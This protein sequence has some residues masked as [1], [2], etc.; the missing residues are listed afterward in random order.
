M[1]RRIWIILK[2]EYLSRLK[3]KGFIIGT[4]LGPVLILGMTFLPA[5]LAMMT[6]GDAKTVY[7]YDQTG[8]YGNDLLSTQQEKADLKSLDLRDVKNN[9]MAEQIAQEKTSD[10]LNLKISQGEQTPEQ[11]SA[12]MNDSLA[13][14]SIYGYLLISSDSL[15]KPQLTFYSTSTSDY[16]IL[17]TLERRVNSL[18]RLKN[19]ARL[20]VS[21]ETAK[22]INATVSMKVFKVTESG[23]QEDSGSSLM[24]A[25]GMGFFIYMS[26]F[27]YGSIVM[28][29]AMEEKQSRIV[30]VIISSVR[31][32]D[33]L[34]GKILGIGLL[35]LTQYL[36]WGLTA[37][38]IGL[39]G[40]A[41][42][43]AFAGPGAGIGFSVPLY[44]IVAFIFYFIGGYLIFST[45]Y[46]A[47]GASV[48]NMNDA[49][50]IVTPIAFLIIIPI[51]MI[52]QVVRDPNSTLAV[53]L[54]LIPFF[55]P[56]LMTARIAVEV[57]PWY[58]I[59]ASVI[60]MTL[61]FIGMVW[62]SAKIYRVGVLMYGKRLTFV[63]LIRWMKY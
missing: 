10:K 51:L 56:I 6:L 27:I 19:L 39:Y 52:S 54:S 32:F 34:M 13:N 5:V 62:A 60:L 29:S 24:L 50:Q 49:Q 17:S 1:N 22:E 7:I 28:Q 2:R 4:I 26:M 11:F 31:P 42:I 23:N 59:T 35:G 33:L 57:P 12:A 45:I 16:L 40:A 18:F 53:I 8:L 61:T 15:G 30:E 36:I 48:D 47:V 14:K 20:G 58:E 9:E 46:A 37:G 21:P 38:L 55:S 3:S 63:E 25:F 44:T 41:M 43:S